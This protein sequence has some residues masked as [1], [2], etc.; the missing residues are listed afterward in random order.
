VKDFEDSDWCAKRDWRE[1]WLQRAIEVVSNVPVID[2]AGAD[3]LDRAVMEL[4]RL[5]GDLPKARQEV[6][7]DPGL[8]AE[9]IEESCRQWTEAAKSKGLL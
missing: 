6:R 1:Y 9:A 8:T 7:I 2:P 4:H 5:M 3:A